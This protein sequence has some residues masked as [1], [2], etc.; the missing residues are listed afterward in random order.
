MSNCHNL[1]QVFNGNL[2]ITSDK[3]SKLMK[4]RDTLMKKIRN[5]FK[6]NYP[7]YKPMFRG[8][9]SYYMGTMIRTK[10]DTCDLDNGVYFFPKPKETGTTLQKW[11]WDAVEDSTSEKP[12]HREKCVRVI[13]KGDYHIDLP[14]YYKESET[15]DAENPHLA[16][17]NEEWSKSDPKEFKEWFK[18]NKDKEGQL[19]RMVRYL[20][21]WCDNRSKKMPT[22]LTMTM[23]AYNNRQ[24]NT[25]DDIALRN[26]LKGIK[27]SLEARWQCKMPTTPK[28]DLL[29]DYKGSKDYFFEA[30]EGFIADADQAINEEKN[31]LVASKLWKKHLGDYFPDGEDKDV[32]KQADSLAA[33]AA[34]I[35][36]KNAKLDKNGQIQGKEGVSHKPHRNFGGE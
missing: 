6:E 17:K 25:R 7:D 2:G 19:V 26:T 24:F 3:R 11:I 14:A 36:S 27:N 15:N 34:T 29:K 35:L 9:G 23:L 18:D 31:Q 20:K 13:Y 21:A 1:F 12:Q 10:D 30:I 22:G 8:Q 16:V 5:H 33:T 28:D 4:A 32:D